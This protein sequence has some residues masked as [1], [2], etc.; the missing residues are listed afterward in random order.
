MDAVLNWIWQGSVAAIAT[1]LA[2]AAIERSRAHDRYLT[3]WSALLAVLALPIVSYLWQAGGSDVVGA[4]LSALPV[5]VLSLPAAWWT[6]PAIVV[7]L[8][9]FWSIAAGTRVVRAAFALR[10][11]KRAAERLPVRREA[12]L[13]HWMAV[14][15]EGRRTPIVMSPAVRTAAVLGFGPPV[16]ALEPSL[17]HQLTDDEIDRLVIHEWA[18]VQRHDDRAQMLEW[19]IT[20]VAGW[21]PAVWWLT[22]QL[23]IERE[24]ACD[25]LVVTVTRSPKDYASS[26]VKAAALRTAPESMIPGL[27]AIG[28]SDL[29][30]R[31]ARILSFPYRRSRAWRMAA[32]GAAALVSALTVTIGGIRAIEAETIDIVTRTTSD[33]LAAVEQIVPRPI[34]VPSAPVWDVTPDGPA[35]VAAHQSIRSPAIAAPV[36]SRSPVVAA[37]ISAAIPG[38]QDTH[39]MHLDASRVP[40]VFD[41]ALKG[42]VPRVLTPPASATSTAPMTLWQH[43]ADSGAAIGRQSTDAARAT[44]GYFTRLGTRV[45]GSF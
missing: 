15:A 31:V 14:A 26:L 22:R 40:G 36:P 25:E 45:A 37:A 24:L 23:R 2:L 32:A 19:A 4:D 28:S 11:V 43:A 6:S 10:D 29:R 8:W 3:V 35:I 44:A 42:A 33:A 9:L 13:A 38:E 27:S 21:H 7:T 30:R 17:L 34:P 1:T 39:E 16:I 5:A 41:A 18:H 20:I 12:R